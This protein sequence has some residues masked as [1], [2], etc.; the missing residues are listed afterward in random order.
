MQTKVEPTGPIAVEGVAVEP[1]KQVSNYPAPFAERMLGR[2][3]RILGNLFGLRT[4][5]VNLTRL[6][7]GAVSSLHHRHTSQDEFVWIVEGELT[8]VTDHAET[9]LRAGMCAGFPANG[10]AHHLENR[11]DRDVL[12]LEIGD[13]GQGDTVDYPLDDLQL[14]RDPTEGRL[15]YA[16]KDGSFY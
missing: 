7:P 14:M 1:R 16:R 4:I 6:A 12:Y 15:R 5:G 2:E 3:K 11:T 8:L 10:T 13:R 9:P